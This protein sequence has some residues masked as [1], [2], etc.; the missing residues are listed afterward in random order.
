M[1]DKESDFIL[2]SKLV[3]IIALAVSLFI[4]VINQLWVWP[5]VLLD[6]LLII[7]CLV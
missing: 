4:S 2:T 5:L 6:V 3:A 1:N 7:V